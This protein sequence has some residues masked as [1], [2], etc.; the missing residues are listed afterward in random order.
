[1]NRNTLVAILLMLAV[2]TMFMSPAFQRFWYTKLLHEPYPEDVERTENKKDSSVTA[3]KDTTQQRVDVLNKNKETEI[4]EKTERDSADT[5]FAIQGDTLWIETETIIAGICEKGAM[6]VSMKMKEYRL[7]HKKQGVSNGDTSGLVDLLTP[8]GAGGAGLAINKAVYDEYLFSVENKPQDKK[9]R[10]NRT[11]ERSITFTYRDSLSGK[12]MQKQFDF[13]GEGYKIGLKITDNKLDNSRITLSWPGGIQ[14]SENT[15]VGM[16]QMEYRKASFSD[17]RSVGHIKTNKIANPK[18]YDDPPSGDE[19]WIGVSSKYFFIAMV[20][21]SIRNADLKIKAFEEKKEED[22]DGKKKK[23]KKINYGLSFQYSVEGNSANFWFYAGPAEYKELKKYH[24]QFQETLFPVLSWARYILYADYW[25]PPVAK[26]VLWLLLALNSLVKDYGVSI[27]ILTFLTRLVTYPLTASSMKSMSRMK[28]LQPKIN[29]L[30]AKYKNNPQKMNT[31]MM[32]LYKAEGV[33]PLNPGCLP[34]FLQMPVFIALFVVLQKAIELRGASTI[35]V[36]WVHD[37]SMPEIIFTLPFNIP[38]YGDNFGIMPI[39]MAALT[40][41]QNKMTIKDPNQKAMIYFM[42]IFMLALFNSFASGLVIYW[43][44]SS[45]LQ[46]A[47]QYYME[48][49]KA[50]ASV[51]APAQKANAPVRKKR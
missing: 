23:L 17:G 25:F 9:Y 14:E 4:T 47:Q 19:R 42:P 7:D 40:F 38:L 16:Y 45:V 51:P 32:A 21:D 39:I 31:E 27:L 22:K 11:E 13:K 3:A 26:F 10:I 35:V 2:M 18:N 12:Q 1:M 30:R 49:K 24:L 44:F 43:T 6:L 50:A 48:K 8:G 34:M 28:D 5:S 46:L 37:L 33:N 41:F 15:K 20:A 29:A 36:P